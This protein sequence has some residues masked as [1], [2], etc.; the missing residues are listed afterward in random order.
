MTRDAVVLVDPAR[1]RGGQRRFRPDDYRPG[2]GQVLNCYRG[3]DLVV[4]CSPGIDFDY[5][6]RLGFDGE[7]EVTSYRGSVREAC[8]WSP[9][10][11][12]SGVRRRAGILDSGEQIS[13]AEPD[14]C[15]VR[16]AGR[17]IV[18]PDGAVVRAGAGAP[19]RRPTR[20]VATGPRDR[21][22]VRRPAAG[23]GARLRG[24]RGAGVRRAPAA[25]GT[26]GAGLRCA[27]DPAS[28][29]SGSIPT[30]C[31]DGCGHAAAN[32]C[33]WSSLAS[34]PAAPVTR[35]PTFA[36]PRDRPRYAGGGHS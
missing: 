30:R 23:R 33:R 34:A 13:D 24:P 9:G 21:L 11:A 32:P 19:L 4:K 31:A 8:L 10:L 18:D 6:D 27:G 29:A 35:R 20:T 25:A 3:R 15:D 14:E 36:G 2:L 28:A 26:V 12:G 16:P 7:I 17:W 1:R 5:L 22:P